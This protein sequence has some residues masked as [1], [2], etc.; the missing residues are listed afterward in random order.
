MKIAVWTDNDLDGACSALL[1]R[2]LYK[3]KATDI[4]IKEVSDESF[5]GEYKGW[6]STIGRDY[7]KIFITDL[8]VSDDLL[9][10]VDKSNVVIIDHHQTHFE[11]KD[12]YKSAKPITKMYSSCAKLIFDKF[13]QHFD[14]PLTKEQEQLV[15]LVDD[16][17]NYTLVHS[18]TL[19]LN[20]VYSAYN[21]PRVEKFI[22]RYENGFQSFSILEQNAIRL[23]FNKLKDLSE[24]CMYYTGNLKGF[25]V[26]SVMADHSI[27]EIAHYA[28]KKHKADI[29]IVVN[30]S[31][32]SVSFRK[33]KQTCNID[34]SK[35]ANLLCDGGGHDYASGGKITDRFLKFTQ[36]LIPCK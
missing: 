31:T 29:G 22:I 23:A 36:S 34:L 21:K 24:S 5:I 7:D 33:N 26:V 11:K 15:V 28:I 32:Q 9:P 17:D 2:H 18:D 3:S 27:N 30:P 8:F 10:Y 13:K 1:I 20:A 6:V 16:Y 12:R 14:K 25:K 19:K 4:Y 35:L